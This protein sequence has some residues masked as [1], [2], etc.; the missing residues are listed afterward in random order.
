[1]ALHVA[2]KRYLCAVD[3]DHIASLS[4]GSV[5]SL[6][7]QGGPMDA[8]EVVR[9]RALPAHFDALRLRRWDDSGKQTEGVE[10]PPLSTY[11][12]LLERSARR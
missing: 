9:F 8:D 6:A 12:S 1:V 5:A 11:R 2:A 3:E 10:V 4:H 7:R